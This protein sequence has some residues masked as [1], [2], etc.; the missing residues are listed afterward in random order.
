[1][2]IKVLC[3]C[4]K[5][6]SVK[7][8]FAGRTLKCPECQKPLRI[9]KPKVEEEPAEDEWDLG[10]SAEE[11]FDDEP[12]E[13]PTKSRGGK[14]STS[15]GPVSRKSSGKGKKSKSSNRGLLIGLSAG[16]GVLV[17]GLLTW[18]LWP[19]APGNKFDHEAWKRVQPTLRPLGIQSQLLTRREAPESIPEGV[20]AVAVLV[21]PDLSASDRYPDNIAATI[22]SL[23][24]VIVKTLEMN[25]TKLKQLSEHPGLIGL[26]LSGKSVITA[27]G[28]RTLKPCP[29][30]RH[31]HLE[32]VSLAPADLMP[33]IGEF[34][35]LSALSVNDMPVTDDLLPNL[36]PLKGLNTLSLQ[37]TSVADAGAAS[38]AK[39]TSVKVLF[40]DGTKLTDEGLRSL[41]VLNNLTMFSARRT[42]VSAQALDDFQKALPGCQILK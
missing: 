16:G 2:P 29:L 3:A 30:F 4:G 21:L 24:H 31:L 5:K 27:D 22:K 20:Q 8:E 26:N 28:L 42:S 33:V 35:D 36:L 34:K 39:L 14:S 32:K 40:L 41:K 25:D 37:N 23:S 9:P 38:L 1:M 6:L 7:D 17:V 13:A 11:E 10:D 15:R 19:A 12:A 18:L